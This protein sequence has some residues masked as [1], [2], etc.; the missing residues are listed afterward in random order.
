[1]KARHMLV[2]FFCVFVPKMQGIIMCLA[3][4]LQPNL[5]EYSQTHIFRY[6]IGLHWCRCLWILQKG[7]EKLA[8]LCT[9]ADWF[10]ISQYG[11]VYIHYIQY[12]QYYS[13]IGARQYGLQLRGFIEVCILG[14]KI[15]NFRRTL[16]GPL[17]RKLCMPSKLARLLSSPA[18]PQTCS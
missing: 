9:P 6:P 13:F 16:Q 3:S 2:L 8:V 15:F 14:L 11:C 17:W 1:M 5:F 10:F 18:P 4:D 12:I 7:V